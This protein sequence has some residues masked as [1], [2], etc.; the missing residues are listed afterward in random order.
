MRQNPKVNDTQK[1]A[2]LLPFHVGM[3]MILTQ[4]YL[5]P[6]IATGTAMLVHG[7]RLHPNENLDE[8]RMSMNR[9]GLAILQFMPLAAC[10]RFKDSTQN[11]L[12]G[13]EINKNKALTCE[14]SWPSSR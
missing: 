11:I 10:V 14:A 7:I 8:H 3:E 2:G 12:Q 4:S 6:L 9:D 1:L 13:D 5:P